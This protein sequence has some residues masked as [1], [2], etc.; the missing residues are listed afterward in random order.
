[1]KSDLHTELKAW[2]QSVIRQRQAIIRLGKSKNNEAEML[3][4]IDYLQRQLDYYKFE[5]D[6]KIAG[7]FDRNAFKIQSLLPGPGSASHVARNQQF[8][9]Y[10]NITQTIIHHENLHYR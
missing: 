7:F 10:M 1:M 6:S 8:N 3:R 4:T 9:N 2:I 5:T